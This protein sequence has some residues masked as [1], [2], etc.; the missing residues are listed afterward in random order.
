M[1]CCSRSSII[2]ITSHRDNYSIF[3]SNVV[4]TIYFNSKLNCTIVLHAGKVQTTNLK[5]NVLQEIFS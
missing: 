2:C 5:L 1:Y 4:I 3:N